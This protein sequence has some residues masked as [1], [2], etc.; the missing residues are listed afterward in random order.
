MI[1]AS[2]ET[3]PEVLTPYVKNGR[4]CFIK[5]EPS[6]NKGQSSWNKG[7]RSISE[8]CTDCGAFISG[9]NPHNCKKVELKGDRFCNECNKQLKNKN[10]ERYS[11]ICATCGKIK[12]RENQ[13]I[14]RQNLVSMFGGACKICGYK[15]H[16]F[17]LEFHHI[18]KDDKQGKK[19][20][21]K[22]VLKNPERFDLL[23]NRCHREIEFEQKR[24]SNK[25]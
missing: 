19:H 21:L 5:G 16:E 6:H 22:H 14:L 10:W 8:R 18:Y 1:N 17:C 7:L 11:K 13:R 9:K 20:F 23:C 2:N 25:L 12:Q 15:K 24:T 4:K 3:A